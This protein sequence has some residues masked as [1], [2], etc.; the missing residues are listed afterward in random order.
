MT[1]I[2]VSTLTCCTDSVRNPVR[3]T[4]NRPNGCTMAGSK[5]VVR[6]A[7]AGLPTRRCPKAS[8][9]AVSATAA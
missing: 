1:A 9:I 4:S 3:S 8:R 7:T 6:N 5:P 2:N